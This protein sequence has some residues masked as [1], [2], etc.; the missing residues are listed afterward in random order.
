MTVHSA[1]GLEFEYVFL[2]NLVDKRFPTIARGE[3]IKLP[4]QLVKEIAPEGDIHLQE[5]RRLFYV[6]MTRA[7]R[8]LYFSSANN[9]GGA[10]AKKI[11]RF[12][13]ELKE[14]GL[15]L[16]SKPEILITEEKIIAK[17]PTEIKPQ[18]PAK[19]S[20]TRL[21]SFETCPYQYRFAF[22]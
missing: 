14:H 3:A 2:P 12:L 18:L 16:K 22:I 11:S 8:G 17:A 19:L 1:K 10:R 13:S 4:D 9:Y 21:K 15:T 6:A 7:K 20:F 5:E